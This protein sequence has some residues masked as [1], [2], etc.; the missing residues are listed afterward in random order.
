MANAMP[1]GPMP[2]RPHRGA[3]GGCGMGSRVRSS[4]HG[5]GLRRHTRAGSRAGQ[6]SRTGRSAGLSALTGFRQRANTRRPPRRLAVASKPCSSVACRSTMPR[7]LFALAH[8]AVDA[9][10]HRPAS[11][12]NGTAG[13][14]VTPAASTAASVSGPEGGLRGVSL[15]ARRAP[16][17]PGPP[18]GGAAIGN[19]QQPAGRAPSLPRSVRPSRPVGSMP[20]V[21]CHRAP[22]YAPSH[23]Q[24][25]SRRHVRHPR[26][27]VFSGSTASADAR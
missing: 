15:S 19:R 22:A 27:M 17:H 2:A 26:T 7:R 1:R 16:A 23:P 4:T 9:P 21:T 20:P 6:A 14:P 11:T 10:F 8:E 13:R 18:F 5:A 12:A 24:G 3:Q 25:R